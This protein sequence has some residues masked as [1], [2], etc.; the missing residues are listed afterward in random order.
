MRLLALDT[1]TRAGSVAI[2]D[3]DRVLVEREGDAARSHTERLPQDMLDA[4]AVAGCA[5]TSI[6]VFVVA[7]G[8]GSFTGL[9]IGIATIQGMALA[10]GKPVVGVSALDALA[11]QAAPAAD[12]RTLIGAW[13]DAA[14]H[15]V[16]SGLYV[17]D[18]STPAGFV[19]RESAA[20]EPP[21]AIWRRWHGEGQNPTVMIGDGAAMYADVF[22]VEARL[23]PHAPLA[24]TLARLARPVAERGGASHPA[25]VHPVYVRRPDVE[26]TRDAQA[27]AARPINETR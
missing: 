20:V 12:E 1:T 4:L 16:F 6:D 2:V 8:P 25:A 27:A 18:R 7:A 26:I 14:R 13:M 17:V 22:G 11:A 24:A 15:D 23:V 3:D 10:A 5:A 19:A 21:A 9:R